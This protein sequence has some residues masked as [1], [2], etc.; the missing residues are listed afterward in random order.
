MQKIIKYSEV[1]HN[2]FESKQTAYAIRNNNSQYVAKK[3]RKTTWSVFSKNVNKEYF[4]GKTRA[5]CID[6]IQLKT[7]KKIVFTK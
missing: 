5:S 2:W 6:W 4:E 1:D 7:G 3:L